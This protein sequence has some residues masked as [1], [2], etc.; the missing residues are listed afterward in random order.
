MPAW[1]SARSEVQ[2]MS[3]YG[4]TDFTLNANLH[5]WFWKVSFKLVHLNSLI[6]VEVLFDL[7]L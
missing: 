5:R 6:D 7:H 2:L 3:L 4:P 1:F